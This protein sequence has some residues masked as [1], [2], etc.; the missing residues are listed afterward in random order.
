MIDSNT[1]LFRNFSTSDFM[2][3][4]L[5]GQKV[6]SDSFKYQS[7]TKNPSSSDK[8]SGPITRS[9]ISNFDKSSVCKSTKSKAARSLS[10]KSSRS[11]SKKSYR[12]LSKFKKRLSEISPNPNPKLAKMLKNKRVTTSKSKQILSP[13]PNYV[14]HKTT[15]NQKHIGKSVSTKRI[16]KTPSTA[17][18]TKAIQRTHLKSS[19][20]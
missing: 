11:I 18:S 9:F 1:D 20:N 15:K 6:S 3:L 10:K 2:R 4:D 16:R 19:R 8:M 17:K 5:G 12:K 13:Y 7:F 14:A